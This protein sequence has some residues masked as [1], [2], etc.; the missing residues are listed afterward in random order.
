MFACC[1]GAAASKQGSIRLYAHFRGWLG[2]GACTGE[3][4]QIK[5]TGPALQTLWLK[6]TQTVTVY[7]PTAASFQQISI[8]PRWVGPLQQTTTQTPN[9]ASAYTASRFGIW[10]TGPKTNTYEKTTSSSKIT[11][12]SGS[13]IGM[14]EEIV[15]EQGRTPADNYSELFTK[16]LQKGD[17]WPQVEN[18]LDAYELDSSENFISPGGGWESQGNIDTARNYFG[19]FYDSLNDGDAT[20]IGLCR[21]Q[22]QIERFR[23]KASAPMCLWSAEMER[24]TSVRENIIQQTCSGPFQIDTLLVEP[25]IDYIPSKHLVYWVG[26]PLLAGGRETVNRA[27]IAPFIPLCCQ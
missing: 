6:R 15:Y 2:P 22:V 11:R 25:R 20:A 19:L 13:E 18:V 3:N 4:D 7:K 8:V 5:T 26:K 24:V 9:Y 1:C 17:A 23:R 14:V 21:T 10:G 27:G 16:L 12:K